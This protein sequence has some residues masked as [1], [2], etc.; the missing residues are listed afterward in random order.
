VNRRGFLASIF[1]AA[2]AGAVS[3]CVR[4]LPMP[5]I[6]KAPITVVKAT[7]PG[8]SFSEILKEYYL[9][10]IREQLNASH[11]MHEMLRLHYY[12][13]GAPAPLSGGAMRVLVCGGRNF[14]NHRAVYEALD[15]LNPK[16]TVIIH[17]DCSGADRLA[18]NWADARGVT[19]SV[20]PADWAKHGKVAG[21]VRNE[22]MLM[23]PPDLV[24]AFPG[25]NGTADMVARAKDANVPVIEVRP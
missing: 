18:D 12:Q 10:A 23:E 22:Q 4:W 8:V 2:A 1:K 15:Q 5:A 20:Y 16:P 25:G 11:R 21:L 13:R 17:G 7:Q 14:N 6:A 3:S 9:P 24:L 19:T